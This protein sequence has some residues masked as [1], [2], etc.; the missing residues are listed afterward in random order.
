MKKSILVS[1]FCLLMA[2]ATFAAAP[3]INITG[4]TGTVF[5]SSFPFGANITMQ[6]SHPLGLAN[7]QVPSPLNIA[8]CCGWGHSRM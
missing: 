7:L 4:P 3:T 8:G 5:V 1:I 6:I 2:A